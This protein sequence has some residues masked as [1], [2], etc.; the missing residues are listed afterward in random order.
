M[1]GIPRRTDQLTMISSLKTE[2]KKGRLFDGI[3]I[4]SL[5]LFLSFCGASLTFP[6]LQAQRDKLDCDALCYGSMQ[7]VRSALSMIGTVLV[8]RLSDRYGRLSALYVGT[9]SSLFSYLVNYSGTSITALWISM[10]PSALLNQNFSVMKALFADISTDIGYS[11]SDRASAI[12]RLGMA[13]GF[14]FML[15][16]LAAATFL[17]SFNEAAL[18]AMAM[19]LLSGF[20]L[21]FLESPSE[22]STK[23]HT[24]NTCKEDEDTKRKPD[25]IL[26]ISL[27]YVKSN[28]AGFMHLPA[29]H[30]P[31]ARLLL[32]MRC[33]MALAFH[34]FMIVW[35]VSLKERFNFGP[36]DHAYFMGWIGLCYS[37]SQGFLAKFFIQMSGN[38]STF[39]LQF[40]IIMLSFGRVMAMSTTSLTMVYVIMAGVIVALGVVNTTM[41]SAL[42]R[43]GGHDQLGGLYGV[44]EAIEN[45]AGLVGPGLGGI[46]QRLHPRLPIVSV[47]GVY[48]I[49]L[50]AVSL[51]YRKHI[52]LAQHI[53]NA[54]EDTTAAQDAMASSAGKVTE[55]SCPPTS[56]VSSDDESMVAKKMR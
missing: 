18:A 56:A 39:I 6:F 4:G 35:T 8:G 19:T 28:V 25:S 5:S 3:T 55:T 2:T 9:A 38:D 46:L 16:P 52:V 40:C 13:A 53:P 7:S 12:G 49:V 26:A 33:C 41:S 27:Q 14:S 22:A 37:I 44:F 45:L 51:F 29:L 47:V 34:I 24:P 17:S 43:L 20:L 31:G 42:A 23:K 48:M 15:G 54:K 50:A 1:Q 11:E 32:L 21:T 10:V 30:T 36:Q